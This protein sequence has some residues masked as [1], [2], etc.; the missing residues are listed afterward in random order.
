M[1]Y[2]IRNII[3]LIIV[4]L[5]MPYGCALQLHYMDKFNHYLRENK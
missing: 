5:V 2:Y 1:K 4:A 3:F